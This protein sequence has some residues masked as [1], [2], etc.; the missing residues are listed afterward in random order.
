MAFKSIENILQPDPRFADL[1]V[2]ENGAACRMT[3]ANH[4]RALASVGL[5]GA[6]PAD[7]VAAFDRARNTI[8]YASCRTA[9]PTSVVG[10]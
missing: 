7:V 2:V 4:P 1:C 5:T 6:A 9:R 8:I 10:R 3:L